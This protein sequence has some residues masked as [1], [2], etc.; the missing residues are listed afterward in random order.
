MADAR[1]QGDL[2]RVQGRGRA[3]QRRDGAVA[4]AMDLSAEPLRPP[5]RRHQ[6]PLSAPD[7][8]A[9]C[10]RTTRR[11]SIRRRT[12][13]HRTTDDG[14]T[15]QVISPDLTWHDPKY[16]IVPG[17]PI[18]RDVTGE[19]VYLVDLLDGRVAARAQRAVGRR[20]RRPGPRDARR[21]Q[22]VEER[23]AEGSAARRARAEH[24][25]VGASGRAPPT[26]RCTASCSSTIS[27]PYIYRT[28]DYGATWT[29]LTDGT[30]GIPDDHPTRVVREDP[31]QR[32]AAL[33][34]DRVRLL[35]L[36]RQ[37][38]ARGS[39]CSRICRRRRSPT[40]ACSA[41]IS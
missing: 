36:V 9:S 5:S 31:E 20:E 7:G 27:K 14:V 35:R 4:G 34:R 2:G 40:S 29:K 39:R 18:T 28:D 25:R 3:L 13:L 21:R 33:R 37:R 30:N 24:R 19:E 12:S 32:G 16:Q 15:W 22:D 6:V 41:A 23:H 11:P 26:S 38:R 10:R 8:R 1:R 17:N